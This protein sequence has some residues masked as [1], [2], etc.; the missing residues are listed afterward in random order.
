MLAGMAG[1]GALLV[2]GVSGQTVQTAPDVESYVPDDPTKELGRW[3]ND[4]GQRSP[5]EQPRRRPGTVPL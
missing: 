5:F 3:A 4:L 2:R 1:V